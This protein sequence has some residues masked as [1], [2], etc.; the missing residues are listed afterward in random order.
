MKQIKPLNPV[1]YQRHM[2]HGD[3]RTW[4]ETNCYADVLVELL[5]GLGYE[6]SAA[7]AFTLG[8][9]F[10]GDQW[11][12][13]KFPHDDLYT[14]YG[15]EIQEFNPWRSL[16]HHIDTQIELG[17]P[18]LVEMDSFFLPDTAGTAYKTHHVKTTIAVNSIDIENQYLGYFHGA[19][20]YE[21]QGQDFIDIFQ[22]N[23]L[24]HERMLPPYIEYVK[25][26]DL[27]TALTG[28]DLVDASEEILK[29]QLKK[30]P[31]TNPFIVF[32][33]AFSRDFEWL[34]TED[35]DT[36][37]LYSFATLRQY[38]AC[39]ELVETYLKWIQHEN[40]RN[41]TE[42]I[43]AFSDISQT[44]KAFQF[45]LARA[46]ARKRLMDFSPI[47]TMSESWEKGMSILNDSYS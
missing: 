39:F 18:V 5:H 10:E 38:G 13:F 17:R 8:I 15:I 2:I 37:H 24:A 25:Q 20:Y 28:K 29:N 34:L 11:T 30:I 32:K 6:P 9:D 45:Q 40:Q 35:L 21:L 31:Q 7:L 14:L 4:A 36:F 27:Q 43:T 41:L 42:A 1:T 26:R 46:V 44:A 33:E 22:L 3:S 47:D 12:F 23:G 19:S 16:A